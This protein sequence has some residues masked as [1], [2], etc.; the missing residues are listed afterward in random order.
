M[1][2]ETHAI[3]M[4]QGEDLVTELRKN[5]RSGNLMTSLTEEAISRIVIRNVKYVRI[6]DPRETDHRDRVSIWVEA[7]ISF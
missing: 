7:T 1:T 4:T 6:A 2:T 3:I 5:L